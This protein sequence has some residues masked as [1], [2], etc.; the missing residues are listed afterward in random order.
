MKD[1]NMMMRYNGLD[2]YIYIID[3][4]CI[5][6]RHIS[7][8]LFKVKAHRCQNID[9]LTLPKERKLST[10]LEEDKLGKS[11]NTPP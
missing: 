5:V 11:I 1:T 8:H 3:I 6:Y 9:D 2:P 7:T 10:E 4:Y